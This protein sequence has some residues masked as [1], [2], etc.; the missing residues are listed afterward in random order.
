MCAKGEE[1]VG[2]RARIRGLDTGRHALDVMTVI[3]FAAAVTVAPAARSFY[4][5][6]SGWVRTSAHGAVSQ[7][8]VERKSF[9]A[10]TTDTAKGVDWMRRANL[11][12]F[13]MAS[14]AVF[15]FAREGWGEG[16]GRRL[17]GVEPPDEG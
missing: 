3:R 10:V 12:K 7:V 11:G 1:D 8:C 13:R 5:A 16:D 9:S 2:D 17:A 15:G 14:D 4:Y 6:E